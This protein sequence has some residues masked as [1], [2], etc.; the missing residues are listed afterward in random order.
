M[1]GQ[2]VMSPNGPRLL[3][4]LPAIGLALLDYSI[5]APEVWIPR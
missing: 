1:A 5:T 4:C 3:S 2:R